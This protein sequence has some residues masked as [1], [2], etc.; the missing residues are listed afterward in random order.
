VGAVGNTVAVN[1]LVRHGIRPILF[2]NIQQAYEGL[3][4]GEV[5]AVVDDGPIL[6]YH[7]R[8]HWHGHAIVVGP[9]FDEDNYSLM[10]PSHSAYL[11][12]VNKAVLKVTHSDH[13]RFL[14]LKWIGSQQ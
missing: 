11:R 1:Y 13:Y 10:L 8:E 5:Q 7:V 3:R 9:V 12:A 6:H 2:K 14:N 4:D